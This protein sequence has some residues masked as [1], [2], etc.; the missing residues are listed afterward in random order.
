MFKKFLKLFFILI[1]IIIFF[2][3]YLSFFG[4]KTNKFNNFIYDNF[5]KKF[6]GI[7]IEISDVYLR[8][9]PLNFSLLLD[10]QNPIIKYENKNIKLEKLRAQILLSSLI[11]DK[12]KFLFSSV[13]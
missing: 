13:A 10:T 12:I 9:Q 1:L 2:T 8:L 11:S 6:S 4:L 7:S 5:E 3:S